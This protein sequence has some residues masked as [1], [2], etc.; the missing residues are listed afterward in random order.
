MAVTVWAH[1]V[2]KK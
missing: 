2:C 1:E